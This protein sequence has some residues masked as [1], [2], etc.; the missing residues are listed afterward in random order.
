MDLEKG[1]HRKM[2]KMKQ[3]LRDCPTKKYYE[4][5]GRKKRFDQKIKIRAAEAEVKRIKLDDITKIPR[6]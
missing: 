6:E 2:A 5:L 1:Y 4:Q 3:L